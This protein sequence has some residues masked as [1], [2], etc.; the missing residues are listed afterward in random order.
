V[1]S[2][3]RFTRREPQ[4]LSWLSLGYVAWICRVGMSRGFFRSRFNGD[5]RVMAHGEEAGTVR[6]VG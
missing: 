4:F 3:A 1:E 6:E 2:Y 5:V